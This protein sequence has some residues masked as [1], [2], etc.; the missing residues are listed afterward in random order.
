[1]KVLVAGASS[2]LGLSI[3]KS[4]LDKYPNIKLGLHANLN[5][6]KF[7]QL[8]APTSQQQIFSFVSDLSQ[9]HMC[10]LLIDDFHSQAN[11]LDALIIAVGGPIQYGSVLDLPDSVWEASYILNFSIP[12][13]LARSATKSMLQT[14]S[15]KSIVFISSNGIKYHGGSTSAHYAAHKSAAESALLSIGNEVAKKNIRINIIRPGV[16]NTSLHQRIVGKDM[17]KRVQQIPMQKMGEPVNISHCAT[18]LIDQASSY[19]H[20]QIFTIAGGE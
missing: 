16:I 14:E 18:F 19:I 11:G 9:P 8:P 4:I 7:S 15:A 6:N 13:Q 12:F 3:S 1:M 5:S 20:N 10:E 17:H 2:D